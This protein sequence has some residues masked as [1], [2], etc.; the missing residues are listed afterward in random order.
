L[1]ILLKKYKHQILR[2]KEISEAKDHGVR[3]HI[4]PEHHG[5]GGQSEEAKKYDCNG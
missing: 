3:G 5:R 4:Q 1:V 2:K